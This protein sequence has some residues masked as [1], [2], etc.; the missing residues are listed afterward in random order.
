MPFTVFWFLFFV[1]MTVLEIVYNYDSGAQYFAF[2]TNITF[3]IQKV[4][5]T[6]DFVITLYVHIWRKDIRDGE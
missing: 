2:L 5:V 6:L 3:I 1:S 4:A